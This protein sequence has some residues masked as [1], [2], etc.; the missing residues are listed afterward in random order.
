M[1]KSRPG[2]EHPAN[3]WFADVLAEVPLRE[4]GKYLKVPVGGRNKFTA[5][6]Y[7]P[8]SYDDD[9]T[10]LHP[11][12]TIC[13]PLPNP[14]F[15][16]LNDWAE[17]NGAVLIAMNDVS[18]DTF[19]QNPEVQRDV[20]DTAFKVL[21]LD[22]SR[23]IALGMSGGAN[24]SWDMIRTYPETFGGIVQIAF[25][26]G[27]DPQ[28]PQHYIHTDLPRHIVLAA[29]HGDKDFNAEIAIK[30]ERLFKQQARP[31]LRLTFPGGHETGPVHLREQALDWVYRQLP[32]RPS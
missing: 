7:L 30:G 12:V 18:N 25:F 14:G 15:Q 9:E 29:I 2:Y 16:D 22:P 17:R 10:V 20:L 26:G 8:L 13:A 32:S 31:V 5:D 21:R 3:T 23:G 27:F 4:P 24:T 11:F 1:L 19:R 6:F 28:R